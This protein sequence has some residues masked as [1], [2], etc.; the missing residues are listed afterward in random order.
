MGNSCSGPGLAGMVMGKHMIIFLWSLGLSLVCLKAGWAEQR[1]CPQ[2]Q[3]ERRNMVLH[4][5]PGAE[6]SG[7][8]QGQPY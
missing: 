5:L 7:A 3:E 2:G 4:T 6:L 1:A 8:V